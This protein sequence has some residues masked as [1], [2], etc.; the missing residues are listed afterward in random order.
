[1]C[2]S[3]SGT[4]R[5][6]QVVLGAARLIQRAART[7]AV[8]K[9]SMCDCK[10]APVFA[11]QKATCVEPDSTSLRLCQKHPR[12]TQKEPFIVRR[13]TRPGQNDVPVL[14]SGEFT[15]GVACNDFTARD[16]VEASVGR[17]PRTISFTTP[18]TLRNDFFR[19][20]ARSAPYACGYPFTSS[21]S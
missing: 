1:M 7:G 20:G 6:N 9:S 12:R 5:N 8:S 10:T 15:L 16:T 13:S 2:W 3:E 19:I 17:A 21:C 4:T 11:R 14:R 18:Y